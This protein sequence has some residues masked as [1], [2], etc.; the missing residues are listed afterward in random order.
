MILYRIAS[1]GTF[2]LGGLTLIPNMMMVGNNSSPVATLG[3]CS[4]Y[5]LIISGIGGVSGLMSIKMSIG[6]LGAGIL[7]QGLAFSQMQ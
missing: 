2:C 5:S 6:F 7:L 1:I 3:V 4:S